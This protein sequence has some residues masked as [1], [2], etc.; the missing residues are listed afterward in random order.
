MTE[1][2]ADVLPLFGIELTGSAGL[3]SVLADVL[4]GQDGLARAVRL[5]LTGARRE[6]VRSIFRPWNSDIFLRRPRPFL[7]FHASNSK[8]KWTSYGHA[9]LRVSRRKA[10]ER[11][12]P[13]PPAQSAMSSRSY[14]SQRNGDPLSCESS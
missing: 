4:V 14:G 10:S 2:P 3:E 7:Q 11:R 13:S 12:E 6:G 9:R 8:R 5:V 1:L